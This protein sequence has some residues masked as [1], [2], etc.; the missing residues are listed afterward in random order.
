MIDFLTSLPMFGLLLT[1]LSYVLGLWINQKLRS[2]LANPLI[3]A[4]AF[5]IM[6]IQGFHIPLDHYSQG[7]NFIALFLPIA[8]AALALSIYR[9]YAILKANLLPVLIGTAVGTA[10]SMS[11]VLF[12]CKLFHLEEIMAKSMLA[13]SVTT[14]IAIEITQQQAGIISITVAAVVVTGIFGAILSPLLIRLLHIKNPV[15]AGLAIGTSSHALGT[16]KA[17]EIGEVEGAM[18]SIAIGMAG[19]ETVLFVLLLS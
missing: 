3:I 16:T 2:P 13:K 19:L 11:S 5:C 6:V 10:V 1:S 17:L 18:S 4:V 7:A 8:T 12:F 9:Q 15:A 14:A